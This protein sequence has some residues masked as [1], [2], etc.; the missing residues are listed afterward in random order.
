MFNDF[1]TLIS[2]SHY[3]II[4]VRQD[5]SVIQHDNNLSGYKVLYPV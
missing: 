1:V 4:K 3:T 2:P 5:Y